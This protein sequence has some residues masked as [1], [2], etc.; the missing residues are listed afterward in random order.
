MFMNLQWQISIEIIA[1]LLS[2]DFMVCMHP[3]LLILYYN[4]QEHLKWLHKY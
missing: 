1:R 2:F 3:I 4:M